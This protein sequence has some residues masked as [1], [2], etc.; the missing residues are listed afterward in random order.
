MSG[1]SS[2]FSGVFSPNTISKNL[3]FTL[4]APKRVKFQELSSTLKNFIR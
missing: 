4:N 1:E 3:L 2:L